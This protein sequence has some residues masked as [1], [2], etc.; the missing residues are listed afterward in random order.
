MHPQAS[1]VNLASLWYQMHEICCCS[2]QA[3]LMIAT[4]VVSTVHVKR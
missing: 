1:R 4:A 3:I 2:L